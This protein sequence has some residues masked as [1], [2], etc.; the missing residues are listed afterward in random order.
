MV[1]VPFLRSFE[2]FFFPVPLA[3]RRKKSFALP[4]FQM[5][6]SRTFRSFRKVSCFPE[7]AGSVMR[8]AIWCE[9]ISS[10]T[11]CASNCAANW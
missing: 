5:S 7:S 8:A 3:I 10:M 1:P 2:G 4:L 6:T 11:V 9:Y